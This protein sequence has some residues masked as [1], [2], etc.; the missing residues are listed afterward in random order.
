M[1]MQQAGVLLLARL[2]CQF[3][4]LPYAVIVLVLAAGLVAPASAARADPP[5]PCWT[6]DNESIISEPRHARLF[7]VARL[8]RAAKAGV[9]NE[10][11][12]RHAGIRE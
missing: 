10:D 4:P 8:R 11:A 3:Q 5:G 2:P 12:S 7:I 6:N 9:F 1:F